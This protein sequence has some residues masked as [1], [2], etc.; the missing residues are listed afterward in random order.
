V[1]DTPLDPS[2]NELTVEVMGVR[3]SVP[4]GDFARRRSAPR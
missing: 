4:E 2:V 3:W 1:S